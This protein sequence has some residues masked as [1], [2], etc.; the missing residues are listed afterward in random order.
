MSKK[1]SKRSKHLKGHKG[2]GG[3]LSLK[4]SLA[5]AIAETKKAEYETAHKQV[6]ELSKMLPKIGHVAAAT[7]KANEA[8]DKLA[9]AQVN[10]SIKK[11][12]YETTT[13]LNAKNV[14]KAEY[15][16]AQR[17]VN[18]LTQELQNS[19]I[20]VDKI[21]ENAAKIRNQV[22]NAEIYGMNAKD[23]SSGRT[24]EQRRKSEIERIKSTSNAANYMRVMFKPATA[25]NVNVN[26]NVKKQQQQIQQ[27][28]ATDKIDA[29]RI[30]S[31]I[32]K[33]RK[34]QKKGL[35]EY[36]IKDLLTYLGS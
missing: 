1:M 35:T 15:E 19:R 21:S 2:G 23:F 26:V 31:E 36:T 22:A 20:K 14:K 5:I 30:N 33:G 18:T 34:V 24:D 11:T 16:A 6:L 13:T 7:A 28:L 12:E 25:V 29:K 9:M 8:R 4:L 10:A 27:Q 32:N 17:K 3:D